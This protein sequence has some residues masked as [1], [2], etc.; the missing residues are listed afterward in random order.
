MKYKTLPATIVILLLIASITATAAQPTRAEFAKAMA[1]LK[2]GMTAAQV[3]KALG[4]PDDVVTPYDPGADF[5]RTSEVWGYGTND[6]H[7]S[8]PT[9]GSVYMEKGKVKYFSGAEGT[10]PD[11][12]LFD[13]GALRALLQL[14]DRAGNNNPLDLIRIVNALQ[15]LGKD[16]ALAAISEYLRVASRYDDHE[17]IGHGVF[18]IL[19]LLFEVPEDPGYM[20]RMMVGGPQPAEPKDPKILPRFPLVLIDD[21]PLNLVY[22][23]ALGGEAEPAAQHVDYFRKY[24]KLREHPLHPTD[25]PL[26]VMARIQNSPQWLYGSKPGTGDYEMGPKFLANQLLALVDSVYWV[27]EYN[28]ARI[29]GEHFDRQNWERITKMFAQLHVKWDA[30]RNIYTFSDGTTLPEFKKPV[31]RRQIWDLPGL[32]VDARLIIE[33]IDPKYV[34]MDLV[35]PESRG[36][37]VEETTVRIYP[38]WNQKHTLAHFNIPF[39]AGRD[40]YQVTG[41]YIELEPG[42]PIQAE[43]VS[44]GKTEKSPVFTP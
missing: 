5:T 6:G 23:Y 40:I 14:I 12:Q 18:L 15:P 35:H 27:P 17:M 33:R 39:S 8:F 32:G 37:R 28:G 25:D 20:P 36:H 3:E 29:S 7:L 42:D 31:Y 1:T 2:P 44:K 13:E 21:I 30:D 43:T 38:P 10:P 16:K 34:R 26:S 41:T 11:P 22:G 19:R 24:G 9:L 4:K